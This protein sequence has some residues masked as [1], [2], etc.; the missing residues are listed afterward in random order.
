MFDELEKLRKDKEL[1]YQKKFIYLKLFFNKYNIS[2]QI[3]LVRIKVYSHRHPHLELRRF[4]KIKFLLSS[5][6][7]WNSHFAWDDYG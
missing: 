7:N 4:I 6:Q 2:H 3:N 5:N 1:V